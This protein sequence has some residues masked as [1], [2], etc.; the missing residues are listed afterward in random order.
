MD[1]TRPSLS[2]PE[3]PKGQDAPEHASGECVEP[4]AHNR[5]LRLIEAIQKTEDPGSLNVGY[6]VCVIPRQVNL[7]LERDTKPLPQVSA[8]WATR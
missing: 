1:R 8:L 3:S 4:G 7:R 5:N 2:A 6:C